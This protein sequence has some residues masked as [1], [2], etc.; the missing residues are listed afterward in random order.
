MNSFHACRAALDEVNHDTDGYHWP[1]EHPEIACECYELTHGQGAFDHPC[2]ARP[3]KEGKTCKRQSH[4][5]R[6]EY[7]VDPGELDVLI[8]AFT[9]TFLESCLFGFL[10]AVGLDDADS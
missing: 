1:D 8:S 4:V 5:Y 10:I 3:K 9:G 7:S 2:R 6:V